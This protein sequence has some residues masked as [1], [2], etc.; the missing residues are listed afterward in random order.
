MTRLGQAEAA[1]AAARLDPDFGPARVE[2]NLA[3][4]RARL[5]KSKQRRRSGLVVTGVVLAVAAVFAVAAGNWR[6]RGSEAPLAAVH[7]LERTQFA[8]GSI[9]ELVRTPGSLAVVSAGERSVEL[10]LDAGEARFDVTPNPER[11]FVVHAGEVVVR[12]VGTS[13]TVQREGSRVRVAVE[14]GVV[15]VDWAETVTR[16]HAGESRWF[17]RE[18]EQGELVLDAPPVPAELAPAVAPSAPARSSARERFVQLAQ[19]GEYQAAYAIMAETPSAVGSS[20]D[21]LMLAADSA[22]LSKHPDQAVI[23]LRRITREHRSDSRAPLAAFTLGR[24]LMSQLGRPAEAAEAFALVQKL[25]PGGALAED[26]LARQ[27]EA[28]S[29]AGQRDRARALASEYR[30]RYP[31]GKHL[32]SLQK[33]GALD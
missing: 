10:R 17:P 3:V 19:R 24:V 20:A 27:A 32:S 14:R 30:T 9:A 8:D 12:V 22:R 26:A 11:R 18:L 5:E 28:L 25:A 6:A 2:A 13:F 21:D 29:R 16:L 31:S 4:T 15:E 23:Y 33:L 1:A 7:T